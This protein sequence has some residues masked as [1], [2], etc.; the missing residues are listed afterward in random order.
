MA[1][2]RGEIEP[3]AQPAGVANANAQTRKMPVGGVPTGR[4]PNTPAPLD[5]DTVAARGSVKKETD[6]G[7][8]GMLHPLELQRNAQEERRREERLKQDAAKRAEEAKKL[9]EKYG[10]MSHFF[11]DAGKKDDEFHGIR[12]EDLAPS[13][14]Q[15]LPPSEFV[16]PSMVKKNSPQDKD[17]GVPG[18]GSSGAECPPR[19]GLT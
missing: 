8:V 9:A 5:A 19:R 2:P 7:V 13:L 11:K 3:N 18:G 16:D 1:K 17:A 10:S 4:V 15:P 12:Q 14:L 6:L